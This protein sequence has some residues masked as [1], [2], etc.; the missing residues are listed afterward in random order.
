M[1]N[2]LGRSLRRMEVEDG[3]ILDFTGHGPFG[4]VS[5]QNSKICEHGGVCYVSV[6]N[7]VNMWDL[8]SNELIGSVG[9]GKHR[10]SCFA[11]ETGM[12][13]IGYETGIVEIVTGEG[14]FPS[15]A[16]SAFSS[17][18][19]KMMRLHRRRVTQIV[20]SGEVFYSASADGTICCFDL[21]L[22]EPRLFYDGNGVCAESISVHG[23]ALLA[24]CADKTVKRWNIGSA[25]LED[26]YAFDEQVFS[27]LVQGGEALVF[28]RS[29]ESFLVDLKS[30]ARKSRE[31]Y[32]RIRNVVR[33]GDIIAVQTQNKLFIYKATKDDTFG[34]TLVEKI[35]SNPSNVQVAICGAGDDDLVVLTKENGIRLVRGEISEYIS[36]ANEILGIGTAGDRV[37]S[38]SKERLII[39][40]KDRLNKYTGVDEEKELDLY[41]EQFTTEQL[42]QIGWIDFSAARC[43]VLFE[44]SIVIGRASGLDFYDMAN[45]RLS[46]HI[47]M[48][49]IVSLASY[50]SVLAVSTDTHA[51]FYDD[52]FSVINTLTAPDQISSSSFSPQGDLFAIST[53]D[54][55]IYVY[56]SSELDL[57]LSLYG[58]S[59]PVRSLVISPDSK[60]L[61]SCGS[62]R[63]VK[64]WGLDHGDCRKT[65]M[66]DAGNAI[67][68]GDAL[69]LFADK[70]ISYYNGHNKLK[71]F[72]CYQPGILAM[73]PDYFVASSDKGLSLF[74]ANRYEL[75]P[76]AAEDSDEEA[77]P[78]AREVADTDRYD[79]FLEYLEQIQAGKEVSAELYSLLEG[80]EYTDLIQ[81]LQLLDHDSVDVIVDLISK[82]LD[83]SVI[84][85]SRI[86]LRLFR[87]HRDIV[88]FHRSTNL[89]RSTLLDQLSK[90]RDC[91]GMNEMRTLGEIIHENI[92]MDVEPERAK[93]E[94]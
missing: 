41:V 54:N 45:N 48:Q 82:Q 49:Q 15:S 19:S 30:R 58:H 73:G 69:F 44:R 84:V 64:L 87:A 33:K 57:K 88:K 28:T 50:G 47:D 83:Q 42:V 18:A 1:K 16:N 60:L 39:W 85:N 21:I 62:D 27:V 65:F 14:L 3:F 93:G 90:L 80:T 86:F 6:G 9:S 56:S 20:L 43:F 40:S 75:V 77:H 79:R 34:L 11:V 32:G 26:A 91:V 8:R 67:F 70:Q 7:R 55:K 17:S 52:S 22:E 61:L 68:T 46:K 59:L 10:V 35:E 78:M 63:L 4:I 12:L 81:F 94:V 23:S 36:H 24:A 5:S 66:G 92:E 76:E 53:L 13:V 37:Y 51:T 38:L 89:I 31:K 29:G 25:V 71:S 2:L 72:A 74:T